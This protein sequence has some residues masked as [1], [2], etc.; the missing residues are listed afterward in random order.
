MGSG[1][2]EGKQKF[3][4]LCPQAEITAF[5]GLFLWTVV[6]G[7]LQDIGSWPLCGLL[8]REE[9]QAR[10]VTAHSSGPCSKERDFHTLH[11]HAHVSVI[12]NLRECLTF[13]HVPT[14]SVS[15]SSFSDLTFCGSV[16]VQSCTHLAVFSAA[17]LLDPK[18]NQSFGESI[19]PLPHFTSYQSK[20]GL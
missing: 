6:P 20:S 10:R 2:S 1:V 4:S 8:E 9:S 14:S 5:A 19:D 12:E 18:L 15:H 13:D 11:M 16:S 7:P 17:W 3:G